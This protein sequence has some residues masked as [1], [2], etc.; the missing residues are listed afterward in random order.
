V[1]ARLIPDSLA[2][3]MILLILAALVLAQIATVLIFAESRRAAVQ[4]AGREQVL[5]RTAALVRLIEDTPADLHQ[6]ILR[7]ASSARVSF[8]IDDRPDVPPDGAI[9]EMVA[10]G[11]LAEVFGEGREVRVALSGRT[12]PWSRIGRTDRDEDDDGGRHRRMMGDGDRDRDRDRTPAVAMSVRL[13]DGRWLNAETLLPPPP[14]LAWPAIASTLLIG[15]A[16]SAVV[17]WSVRRIARPLRGLADAADRFGRGETVPPLPEEGSE[18]IRR[19]VSAFNAMQAR[20]R[21]FVSDRTRMLAAISH[22][23]RTPLTSLR[24]R[25]EFVDDD[26]TRERLIATVDE[27]S[28]MTEA[29]LAFARDEASGEEAR[30]TDLVSLVR[31]VADDFT[32]IGADVTVTAPE[33]LELTVRPVALRRALRNLVENAVRYGSRARIA[34]VEQRGDAIMT[35][36][37]D[38]PGIPAERLEDVFDPFVRL[39][40]SRSTETGGVGLGLSTARTIARAHGGDVTLS[41]RA[42]G[43]LTA[44]LRLPHG[45]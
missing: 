36:D 11:T 34:L 2:G 4:A 45:A 25:A 26:E 5:G 38:G 3:R 32:D 15:T 23:L 13:F 22:D 37:D 7:A 27:M 31:A 39:E 6:R 12:R 30:P 20:V 1:T 16:V 17:I 41:N 19:T 42:G 43:G 40:T 18:E 33:R 35:V 14:L 24:L 44:T 10:E 9:P 21:S 29:T 28:R 8:R